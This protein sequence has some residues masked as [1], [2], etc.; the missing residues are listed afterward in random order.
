MLVPGRVIE[1]ALKLPCQRLER[2]PTEAEAPT[3]LEITEL[4]YAKAVEV[5]VC[6]TYTRSSA[7]LVF[8]YHSL[9]EISMALMDWRSSDSDGSSSE[10]HGAKHFLFAV[11]TWEA[12]HLTL[13]H[14]SSNAR[15]LRANSS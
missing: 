2:P 5:T 13:K 3:M 14:L 7:I 6:E 10:Q 9:Y 11:Y 15:D 12:P 4:P 8:R 1:L